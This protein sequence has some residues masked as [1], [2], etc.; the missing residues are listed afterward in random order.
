VY[1][2][3]SQYVYM[4]T[5]YLVN[6]KMTIQRCRGAFG[7]GGY[8]M[9]RNFNTSLWRLILSFCFPPLAQL[10]RKFLTQLKYIV[11]ATGGKG[12]QDM[13]ELEPWLDAIKHTSR[14]FMC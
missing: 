4:M 5:G 6:G 1:H 11:E 9:L 3:A 12:L 7:S 8:F 10:S 14:P 13:I 2:E